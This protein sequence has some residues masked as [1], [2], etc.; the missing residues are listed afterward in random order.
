MVK[1]AVWVWFKMCYWNE[2]N[3]IDVFGDS[4]FQWLLFVIIFVIIYSTKFLNNCSNTFALF[5]EK[6]NSQVLT[7]QS[8]VTTQKGMW[9]KWVPKVLF[10]GDG[11]K[12]FFR[13]SQAFK[14]RSWERGKKR[15]K[16]T[17]KHPKLSLYKWKSHCWRLFS[18]EQQPEALSKL[19]VY[20]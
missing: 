2:V 4:R 12:S 5:T 20:L 13:F 6:F 7:D 15:K 17:H 16:Q 18:R 3:F 10:H 19:H 9:D 1:I 8:L 14:W 11:M